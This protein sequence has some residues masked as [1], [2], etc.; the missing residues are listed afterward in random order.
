MVRNSRY[1]TVMDLASTNVITI[2][3][4]ST[5]MTSMKTMVRYSFRRVPVADAGTKR[6]E[7]IVTSM[8]ILDFLGGGDRHRLVREKYMGN[9]IA[10]VN[11]EV[12]EIMEKNV[13]SVHYTSSWEDALELMLE[14]NVGGAPIV[15]DDES[16]VG[17][18]TERDI[19][20]FL[21]SRARYDGRVKDFMTRGVITAEPET[22]IEDAIRLMVSKRFRRL[23]VVKDGIL[24]G[25]LTSS[26]LVHYF[27]GEAFKKLVTGDA[28]DVLSQPVTTILN[29]EKVLKYR[30]P[31]VVHPE[32]SITDVVRKM[33]EKNQA[34]ALVV[35]DT[36]EGIIT[37]RDLMKFLCTVKC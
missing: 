34:A 28:S 11:E 2:P 16:V 26:T 5:I 6:L 3:P 1:G 24:L 7:G 21:A 32:D 22:S 27:S 10:A 19:M 29:N 31:L 12:R 20:V 13:M 9:L 4:T 15:D 8:D 30:E 33:I 14:H 18:I 35:K 23:P 17:I 25:L 36:L 37:E